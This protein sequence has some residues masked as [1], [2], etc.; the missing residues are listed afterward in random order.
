M[1][2]LSKEKMKPEIIHGSIICMALMKMGEFMVAL[3]GKTGG[4]INSRNKGGTYTKNFTMPTNPRTIYQVGQRNLFTTNSQAW[5]NLTNV[6]RAAW[7]AVAPSFPY[8]NAVGDV[9]YLSGSA[10]YNKLNIN[11]A[12]AGQMPISTPPVPS[13]V[14]GVSSI[15]VTYI[16]GVIT[17]TFAPTPVPTGQAMLFWATPGL[18]PGVSFVKNKWRLIKYL[19]AAVV[20]PQPEITTYTGRFGAAP[21]GTKVFFGL[22]P[23]N[24]L[25]GETGLMLETSTIVS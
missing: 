2:K 24:I 14:I 25:T 20:S 4:T 9:K 18:S 15:V 23:V 7:I 21:V 5:R 19:A 8:I 11:L 1:D 17:L 10:L 13:G 22:Q 16:A 12:L 6:Q 3:S